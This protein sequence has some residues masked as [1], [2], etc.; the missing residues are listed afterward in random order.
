MLFSRSGF[1]GI[2]FEVARGNVCEKIVRNE[3]R[4]EKKNT[5]LLSL[6]MNESTLY[7]QARK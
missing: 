2:A 6:S 4:C 3:D 1:D 5:I 7:N